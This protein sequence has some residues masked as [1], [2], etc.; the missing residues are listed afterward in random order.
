[1]PD[2]L[3]IILIRKIIDQK[4]SLTV[5]NLVSIILTLAMWQHLTAII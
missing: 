4:L 3:V 1:M 2:N 5:N